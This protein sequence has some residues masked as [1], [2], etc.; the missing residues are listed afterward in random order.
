MKENKRKKVKKASKNLLSCMKEFLIEGFI[1]NEKIIL[2]I[3]HFSDNEK[4]GS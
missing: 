3:H 4:K 1:Q 2:I